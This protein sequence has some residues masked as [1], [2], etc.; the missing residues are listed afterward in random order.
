MNGSTTNKSH[1]EQ[2]LQIA[3]LAHAL[4][5]SVEALEFA[6]LEMK[7]STLDVGCGFGEFAGV[8]FGKL[9]CGI[10]VS[11]SD[12]DVAME[13]KKYKKTLLVDARKMPFENNSF[14]NAV[15]VS[16]LEHIVNPELVLDEVCRVLKPGG[17]FAFSVPTPELEKNLLGTKLFGKRYAALHSSLFKHVSL[18][19]KVWWETEIKKREFD[20]E[21]VVGTVSPRFANLHEVLLVGAL[22]SQL[23]RWFGGKRFVVKWGSRWLANLFKGLIKTDPASEINMFFVA[24]KK[25]NPG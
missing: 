13:E 12:L 21:K 6:K 19:S 3:P 24:R 23:G 4:W 14:E 8:V 20:I 9:E 7:G 18:K 15:S 1:L 17:L 10:D 5:R 16:V 22:P 2:F 25:G 11:Q